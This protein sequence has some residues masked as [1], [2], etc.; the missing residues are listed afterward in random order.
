MYD[1]SDLE[2]E[3]KVTKSSYVFRSYQVM[4]LCQ[5]SLNMTIVSENIV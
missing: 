3:I 5:F 4:F 1:T 2:N